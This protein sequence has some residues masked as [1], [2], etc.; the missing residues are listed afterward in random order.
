M[1]KSTFGMV[2]F[3]TGAVGYLTI[4]LVS[5]VAA[6]LIEQIAIPITIFCALGVTGLIICIREAYSKK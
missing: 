2:L 3:I 6:L 4:T 5:C 1:K